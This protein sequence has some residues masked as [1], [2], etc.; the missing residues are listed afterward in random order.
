MDAAEKERPVSLLTKRREIRDDG[1]A[2]TVS[3]DAAIGFVT[4]SRRVSGE[5]AQDVLLALGSMAEATNRSEKVCRQITKALG[6]V[7]YREFVPAREILDQ[8]LD[9]RSAIH[10]EPSVEPARAGR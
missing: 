7:T 9:I 1:A 3:V 4:G 5:F 2:L 8:L 10:D 6:S